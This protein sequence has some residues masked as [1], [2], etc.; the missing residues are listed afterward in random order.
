ML[1]ASF[2]KYIYL[3]IVTVLTFS[4]KAV[5][6]NR[7]V[8]T[9]HIHG[10]HNQVL[11][12]TVFL[13]LFIG[14]RPHSYVFVDTMN[15]VFGYEHDEG[16]L[17]VFDPD[18]ENFLFDNIFQFF[19]SACLG[20]T[21]F[22]LLIATIYFGASAWAAR[23]LFPNDTFAAYIVFLAAFST[24]SYGTNGIKAGAATSLFLLALSYREKIIPCLLLM[25]ATIGMHHSMV[26]PVLAFILTL[27]FKNPKWYFYGWIFSALIAT[28]HIGVFQNLFAGF[29]DESGA[30]YLGAEG[31]SDGAYLSGFRPDFMLYSAMPVWVGYIAKFK[32]NIKSK[33]YDT[34]LYTYLTTNAV[35]MLCMYASFTNRIAYLSWC[36]YPIVLI[37]PFLNENWGANRYR[38]FAKVMIYHLLFTIFM[39]LIYYGGIA[40]LLGF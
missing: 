24:F 26:V 10:K 30:R 12:L 27:F 36:L 31:Y 25:Y 34:L 16:S 11:L 23:R 39:E 32:K 1:L 9:K 22:F 19:S 13:V 3:L 15:Y 18:A 17:F 33:T 6:A 21:S 8:Q 4:A 29:A 7:I 38:V 28:A 40:K 5:Y 2:Y 35:W 14:F 37:Y 20:I